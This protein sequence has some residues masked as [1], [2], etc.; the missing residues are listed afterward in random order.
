[1]NAANKVSETL[2]YATNLDDI[3]KRPPPTHTEIKKKEEM[4]GLFYLSSETGFSSYL[5]IV[6]SKEYLLN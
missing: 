6:K 2:K 5:P 1:M 4:E 3:V